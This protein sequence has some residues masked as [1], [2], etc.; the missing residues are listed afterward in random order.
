MVQLDGI[1]SL[2]SRW[3]WTRLLVPLDHAGELREE[4]RRWV[5]MIDASWVVW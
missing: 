2:Q 5:L 3:D 4:W 1:A